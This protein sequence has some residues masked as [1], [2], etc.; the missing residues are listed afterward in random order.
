MLKKIT[1][2]ILI[3]D[4]DDSKDRALLGVIKG[5]KSSLIVDAGNS[6]SHIQEFKELLYG[7]GINNLKYLGITHWHWDH[8]FGIDYMNLVTLG[9]QKTKGKLSRIKAIVECGIEP[10]I[11]EI[12][13]V[14]RLSE[15]KEQEKEIGNIDIGYAKSVSI[16]LGDI[17]CIMEHVG[18]DHSDDSSI[19]FIPEE[20]V[21]FL[22]D[23]TYRGFSG[24][25]RTHNLKN[26]EKLSREI[27]K[28]DCDK[29][30][31]AHKPMYNRE[32][33]E[34]LLS[35]M[36]DIGEFVGEEVDYDVI[37]KKISLARRRELSEDE[38][39]FLKAYVDGNIAKQIN[40]NK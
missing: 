15:I 4:Y 31:T 32:E 37:N 20:K 25:L 14:K 27:L 3:M 26:V 18:G 22:G 5:S 21:M 19:I 16:D 2:N 39:F 30:F 40:N 7:E 13:T 1:E 6:Y 17:G 29:F 28:Y 23:I 8:V 35:T 36:I 38:K 12:N 10:K 33:M 9:S 11:E 34:S 24:S